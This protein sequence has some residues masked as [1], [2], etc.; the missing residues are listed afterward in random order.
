MESLM[1]KFN[2]SMGVYTKAGANITFAMN[3][4]RPR[5]GKI[6]DDYC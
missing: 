1:I 6:V 5:C 4:A 2:F 3:I